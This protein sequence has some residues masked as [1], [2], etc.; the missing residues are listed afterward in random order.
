MVIVILLHFAS[1]IKQVPLVPSNLHSRDNPQSTAALLSSICQYFALNHCACR[2]PSLRQFFA[3]K[4]CVC[5]V[6]GSQY[7]PLNH[8]ACRHP[9]L[10]GQYCALNHCACRPPS[11]RDH[12]PP[13]SNL[14]GRKRETGHKKKISMTRAEKIDT[15]FGHPVQNS[16]GLLLGLGTAGPAFDTFILAYLTEVDCRR[17]MAQAGS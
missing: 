1:H 12:Y 13:S 15:L 6:L 10:R 2:R 8:C 14:K 16:A 11:L 5:Q 3:L 7:F 17:P 4:N 9:S